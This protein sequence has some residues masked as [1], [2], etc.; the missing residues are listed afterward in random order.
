MFNHLKMPIFIGEYWKFHMVQPNINTYGK[1]LK[2]CNEVLNIKFRIYLF[3][4]LVWLS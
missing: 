1:I 4:Y 3:T 2:K